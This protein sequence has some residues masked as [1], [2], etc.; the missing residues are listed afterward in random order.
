MDDFD[1]DDLIILPKEQIE[2]MVRAIEFLLAHQGVVVADFRRKFRLTK[3]AY[4]MIFDFAMPFY[5]KQSNTGYWKAKYS[6]QRDAIKGLLKTAR[7]FLRK[8]H[9]DREIA[10]EYRN[11]IKKLNAVIEE[12]DVGRLNIRRQKE[13]DE[14]DNDE[15]EDDLADYIL[16]P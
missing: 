12:S 9:T 15:N 5:R 16:G 2:K 6:M 8:P 10:D 4:N 11:L 3:E 1:C 13:L 14:S 7:S